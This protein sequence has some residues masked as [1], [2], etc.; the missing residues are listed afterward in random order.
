MLRA[1]IA[2]LAREGAARVRLLQSVEPAIRRE[3]LV[4][5]GVDDVVTRAMHRHWPSPERWRFSKLPTATIL[6]LAKLIG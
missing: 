5:G 4:S 3:V 1:I 6:G 2:G